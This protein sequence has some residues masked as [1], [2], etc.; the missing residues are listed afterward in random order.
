MAPL[1]ASFVTAQGS[2]LPSIHGGE[3]ALTATDD[4][5]GAA[6]A[7]IRAAMDGAIVGVYL[8][9][10]A[11]DAGLKPDSDLDLFVVTDRALTTDER[12]RLVD[13]LMPISQRESRPPGWRPLE[14]T[15]VEESQVN[16]WRYP[17][18]ME[19]LYGEWLRDDLVA[20]RIDPP[21]FNP[22]LGILIT[23]VR[24]RGEPLI[25]PLATEVL[26]AVPPRDLARAMV[27]TVPFL[28]EDLEGDTRNVL[29]TLARIWLT[30]GT[31]EIRSK[32]AAA[33]WVLPRLAPDDRPL[34]ERARDLYRDGGY[35]DWPDQAAA[36]QLAD[37]MVAEI[38]RAL[39]RPPARSSP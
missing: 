13:G 32:D 27:D 10:S 31:G 6:L 34:L 29:L 21:R 2:R 37:R 5:A 17:P 35:G 18:R 16:P 30:L 3:A 23:M 25:G 1:S 26:G 38:R 11:V 39:S 14:L 4:Q 22:D 19:L 20:G 7:A 28:L 8:Y 36:R 24:Q 33:D 12:K 9:G 15:V